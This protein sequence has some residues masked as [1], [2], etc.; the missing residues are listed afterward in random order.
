[1]KV[2]DNVKVVKAFSFASSPAVLDSQ[3]KKHVHQCGCPFVLPKQS[4]TSHKLSHVI[5]LFL[6]FL[7]R[8][9]CLSWSTCVLSLFPAPAP[10][11]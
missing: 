9:L 11:L 10:G 3:Q 1:M 2:Q 8:A 7:L 4:V 6:L 5:F